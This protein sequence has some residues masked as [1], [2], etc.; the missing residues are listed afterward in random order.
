MK[1]TTH[2]TLKLEIADGEYWYG[3]CSR[4][5][6]QYPLGKNSEYSHDFRRNFT[7]NQEAPFMLSSE[8]KYIWSEEPFKV[9]VKDGTLELEGQDMEYCEG[10]GDLRSAFCTAEKRHFPA[11]GEYPPKD[12]ITKPQYN[13]WIELIY[14]Q[15]QKDILK[16][17]HDI[18][19]HGL[20]AGIIMIDDNWNRYYGCWE[21]RR[22]E[23]P[24][25]RAMCDELH[26]MGFKV[27]VW[28]CPFI[29]PDSAEFRETK[30]KGLLVCDKDG[31]VA[32]REWWNGFSAILDLSN[33]DAEKWFC[34]KI[35][36]L[37][38][39]YGVDGIKLDAGDAQYYR[40]DDKT[41]GNVS[42]HTQTELWAKLGMKYRYNEFRACFKAAG[43]PLVQRLHDKFHNWYD[44]VA[45]LVPDSLSQGILGYAFS[46]PD[47]IGGGSFTDF[48][49]GALTLDPE[50]FVRYAQCA[51]LLPMMQYSAA[52]WRVL[53]PDYA[54]L[55]IDAGKLHEKYSDVILELVKHAAI[56]GEPVVR[57]M[58]Y[59]FPH[60]GLAAISDQFMLGDSI[61]VAPVTEKG[62]T[63]KKVTLPCGKWKYC[64]TEIYEGGGTVTVPA[65]LNVLPYFELVD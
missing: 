21:F 54:Q 25:P 59:C 60:Q 19:E 63:E 46:C 38:S 45:P 1:C 17:A 39:E 65:P 33:P 48:L 29:S 31:R 10:L 61:L 51:A 6:R 32:I 41:Y 4:H 24:D 14:N 16:Y 28:V 12:F 5:G 40:D 52:P 22:E 36:R 2:Q 15:N 50:L 3:L 43:L 23:F 49:P 11:N 62:A 7:A 53:P 56:T 35:D 30:A 26:D 27:M 44:G 55:C 20:P 18:I 64:D 37:I 57:Y 58:E 8:G 34:E 42:A 9:T 47:M 13:T